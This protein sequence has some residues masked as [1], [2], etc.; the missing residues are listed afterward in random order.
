MQA[1][2]V[3]MMRYHLI[4]THCGLNESISDMQSFDVF[5]WDLKTALRLASEWITWEGLGFAGR[6]AQIRQEPDSEDPDCPV[7]TIAYM[8]VEV[9]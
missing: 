2:G 5:V 6:T 8:S 7:K 1:A 9:A 3:G 4:E